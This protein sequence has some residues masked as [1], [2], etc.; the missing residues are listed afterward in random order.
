[1]I[2]FNKWK[3]GYWFTLVLFFFF[4]ICELLHYSFHFIHIQGKLVDTLML[5]SGLLLFVFCFKQI[6]GRSYLLYDGLSVSQWWYYLFFVLGALIKKHFSMFVR[7]TDNHYFV[8]SLL[9][10]FV[11]TFIARNTIASVGFSIVVLILSISGTIIVFTYFRKHAS[12][13]SRDC[14][15]GRILIC[16]GKRTMDIYM[17]HFFILPRHLGNLCQYLELDKNPVV[18]FFVSSVI[19]TIVI[20]VCLLLGSVI[21]LNPLMSRYLLGTK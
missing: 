5:L 20:V 12:H 3:A 19:A 16:I 9:L 6:E 14:M 18:E 7:L 21:R 4:L 15:S 2:V 11:F 1:M 13:F 17:I 10:L 8:S